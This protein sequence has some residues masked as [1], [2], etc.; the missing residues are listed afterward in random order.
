MH[1]GHCSHYTGYCVSSFTSLIWSLP[2]FS[3]ALFWKLTLLSIIQIRGNLCKMSTEIEQYK[4][5]YTLPTKTVKVKDEGAIFN[6]I[7]APHQEVLSV[8]GV[9]FPIFSSSRLRPW[10]PGQD[11]WRLQPIRGRDGEVWTNQRP[12]SH[13][14]LSVGRP[15]DFPHLALVESWS[16]NYEEWDRVISYWFWQ[17]NTIKSAK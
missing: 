1:L 16:T 13:L 3:N 2:F 5:L 8:S 7:R 10:W 6:N 4:Y 17:K 15:W 14:T 12:R 11:V 9:L